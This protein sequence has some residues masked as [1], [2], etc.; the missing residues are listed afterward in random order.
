MPADP[1]NSSAMND[2]T[3]SGEASVSSS[4]NQVVPQ[5]EL[6][7]K[8]RNLPGMPDPDAEVIALSPKTLLA[9]NRFVCEICSKGFQRDQNLQLHRRGHNLPWK[10]RQRTSK[11]VKKRVYVCPEPSCVHHHPS[12]ALGDLTGIKKHFCR[13]HGE[14]KWKCDKCSKKYAVQS[15][16]KAHSKICGT[17][18]YKCDCGTLFS[19][20][21]SF[22]THRAFCD[23]LAQESAKTLPEKPPNANE[24]PKTTAVASPSP[25]PPPPPPPAPAPATESQPPP[26]EAALPPAAAPKPLITPA[27]PPSS[28]VMSFISS[29]Q[30]PVAKI[31]ADLLENPNTNPAGTATKQIL[32]ETTAVASLT[33]SCSSSCSNGST[34]S[35]VF[36]SLFA[37]STASGSLPSQAPGFAVMF[38][39]MPPDHTL[40]MA[41]PSSTEPISL[42]LAMNHSSSI[43]RPAGQER[44]QYAPAPQPAMSATAL[45]QKAA[46]MGA[47]ATSS[48][49]LRG[50]GVMS[51]TSSSNGQHE[52]SGRP[53][54]ANG[55]SLSAGLGLGLPCDAGSGLKELMMGTPSVFGPKHPTLDLLGLGM[56]ASVGPTPGLSALITSMGSNM[57]MVTSAGA[58]GSGDF[59]G[60]DLGRNS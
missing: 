2:S 10:L 42:G 12:R 34:S 19:R 54:D 52:W 9:T 13:K 47:A 22:I 4:G 38:R 31:S 26:P 20:R 24:E 14:K 15:D 5:K 50:F 60:K 55:A 44:R 41:S 32:E 27:V 46:Q 40:E 30:N 36:G 16:L 23:A 29:V 28:A 56:A 45:L 33:G 59:S 8:K 48:S 6:V 17:R 18:E 37:S 21:D 7:K 49:L 51:S 53:I 39:A 11:E 1:D 3:G 43:F 25:P 57:D 58:F 35:S